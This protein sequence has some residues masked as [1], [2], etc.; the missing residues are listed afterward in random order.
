MP[1]VIRS[2]CEFKVTGLRPC[3][4]LRR[5]TKGAYQIG[6]HSF[7]LVNMDDTG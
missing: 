3:R 2:E 4:S 7:A 6:D 5:G 1:G